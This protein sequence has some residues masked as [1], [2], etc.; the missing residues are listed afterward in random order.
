MRAAW[1]PPRDVDRLA[2][3]RP[4]AGRG[5][6]ERGEDEVAGVEEAGRA[7]AQALDALAQ[8]R[9]DRRDAHAR[10]AQPDFERPRALEAFGEPL[11]EGAGA[12]LQ[13][14][15]AFGEPLGAGA[16]PFEAAGQ[17]LR[18]R[19]RVGR[20]RVRAASRPPRSG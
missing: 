17:A 7:A 15:E 11:A 14:A 5:A 20:R 1:P 16:E 6:V 4:A 3:E 12:A 9:G 8:R 13:G 2:G 10:A 18:R 19:P